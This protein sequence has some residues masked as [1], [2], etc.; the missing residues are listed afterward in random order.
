MIHNFPANI[1]QWTKSDLWHKQLCIKGI[2]N[3]A[4]ISVKQLNSDAKK[5]QNN[6][7]QRSLKGGGG[8]EMWGALK[9]N[10]GRLFGKSLRNN[11]YL[12]SVIYY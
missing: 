2:S 1:P 8:E 4:L 11:P 5:Q 9:N 7:S 6:T 10:T 12:F 3:I